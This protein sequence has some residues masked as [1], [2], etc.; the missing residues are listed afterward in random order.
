M[1][2][3][4]GE[5]REGCQEK[6]CVRIS[7]VLRY[8]EAGQWGGDGLRNHRSI[9]YGR[10]GQ[11]REVA[12]CYGIFTV[13]KGRKAAALGNQDL[14]GRQWVS[15]GQ[16]QGVGWDLSLP[17]WQWGASCSPQKCHSGETECMTLKGPPSWGGAWRWLRRIQGKTNLSSELSAN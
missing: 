3:R 7:K 17:P 6:H 12:Q 15:V 8:S 2:V 16:W 11:G 13:W 1:F 4:L 5:A 10:A 14:L 9:G